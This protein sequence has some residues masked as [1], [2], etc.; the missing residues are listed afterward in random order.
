MKS[1][2]SITPQYS[3]KFGLHRALD[4]TYYHKHQFNANVLPNYPHQSSNKDTK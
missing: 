3:L 1:V 4:G 2:K